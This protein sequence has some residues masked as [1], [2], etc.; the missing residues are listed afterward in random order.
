VD[1][2]S[3]EG[4]NDLDEALA[5][6]H[7]DTVMHFENSGLTD[8]MKIVVNS[9][10]E[11]TAKS[12]EIC[13][14]DRTAKAV[15]ARRSLTVPADH[16]QLEPPLATPQ[17]TELRPL[18]FVKRKKPEPVAD[19]PQPGDVL[20][21]ASPARCKRR[22][23]Q[24]KAA[25]RVRAYVNSGLIIDKEPA[26]SVYC[27]DCVQGMLWNHRLSWLSDTLCQ[28]IISGTTDMTLTVFPRKLRKWY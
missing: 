17:K 15:M 23:I 6:A 9:A 4:L 25:D 13:Y 12:S 20:F 14:L 11:G 18:R 5:R 7:L 27:T 3:S 8:A 21:T 10:R 1:A 28:H 24:M 26:G 16:K 22:K 19:M 2:S